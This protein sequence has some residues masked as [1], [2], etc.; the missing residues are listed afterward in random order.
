MCIKTKHKRKSKD[1][2]MILFRRIIKIKDYTIKITEPAFITNT[3]NFD[4]ARFNK[5]LE[6]IK[7]IKITDEVKR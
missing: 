2:S 7:N 5:Q 6:I 3:T 4:K 1:S